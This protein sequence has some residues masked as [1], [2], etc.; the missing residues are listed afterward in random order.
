MNVT[1]SSPR[2]R[3]QMSEKGAELVRLQ[4][5]MGRDLLWDGNPAFW[6]GRSPLLFP[7]VG[8]VRN[9]HIRVGGTEYGLPKH[10]FARTALFAIREAD[11]SE[12]RFS[13]V[14]GETTLGQ[15]PFRFALDVSY[16]IEDATLT[17]TASVINKGAKA[18]PASFGFHPAFRWPLPYGAP[19]DAHAVRFE[20]E[21]AAPVRRPVDGLISRDVEE[22][23]VQGRMLRLQDHLFE[24]DALVFDRL[25]SRSVTYGAPDGGSI[26]I[27]FPDMP[28]LGIWT[29]PGAGFICIEPWQGHADPE[30][31][32]GEFADK[33][34][35]V[36]I[37][38]SE[39]RSFTMTITVN[40]AGL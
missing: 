17:I 5:E 30:G 28:H 29:K 39:T 34:G 16:R 37:Q 36:L 35:N 23:P 12:C 38:P 20:R 3:A 19:R 31:F 15:Y 8:R 18:M 13:L 6:T 25:E 27:D 9:D 14:S 32:D 22:S 24:A 11:P 10:G 21:E 1:I 4:D 2:L 40:D 7:I 33:P 26:R